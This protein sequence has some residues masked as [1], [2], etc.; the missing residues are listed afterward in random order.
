MIS[1]EDIILPSHQSV[2]GLTRLVSLTM[3]AVV[4]NPD[5]LVLSPTLTQ[6]HYVYPHMQFNKCGNRGV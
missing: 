1:S 5:P 2:T 6:R 3:R 4:Q